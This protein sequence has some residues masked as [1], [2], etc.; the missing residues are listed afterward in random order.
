MVSSWYVSKDSLWDSWSE[1]II[2][3]RQASSLVVG[4]VSLLS[5]ALDPL[6][7]G[8]ALAF[9]G[10]PSSAARLAGS[11]LAVMAALSGAGLLLFGLSN[12][13][14]ASRIQSI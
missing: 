6:V 3:R 1:G 5:V 10:M 2:L 11:R 14:R 4:G 12:W 7:V 9:E 13:A 8:E